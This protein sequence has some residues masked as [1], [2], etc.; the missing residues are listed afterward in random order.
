MREIV[1]IYTDSYS[2][3]DWGEGGPFYSSRPVHGFS[4]RGESRESHHVEEEFS[5]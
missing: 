5:G 3:G 2:D 4:D 1:W